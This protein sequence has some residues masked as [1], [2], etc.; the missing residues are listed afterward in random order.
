MP[1]YHF[2]REARTPYSEAWSIEDA[3]D[4]VG[5]V[6]GRTS[7][8]VSVAIRMVGRSAAA[9]PLNRPVYAR[10]VLRFPR[11]ATYNLRLAT[12]SASA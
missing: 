6:A 2:E 3:G 12:N 8:P 5:R 11:P 1:E 4:P 10:L 9:A 7:Q